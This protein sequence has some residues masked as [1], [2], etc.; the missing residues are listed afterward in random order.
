MYTPKSILKSVWGYDSFREPQEEIIESVLKNH[1]TIALLPTGGGKSICYQIPA[2]L[3]SGATL[4]ISPLISLMEDQVQQLQKRGVKA[5]YIKPGSSTEDIVTLFDAIKYGELKI[6]YLSP[7]RL[8]SNLIIEKLKEIEVSLLAIDEAHCISEWGHD[9]RPS[10]LKIKDIR[11]VLGNPKLIAVTASATNQVL[12]DIQIQLNCN[13][14]T[15]FKQ[16]FFR[17][18]LAYQVFEIESKNQRLFQI[19]SK[20]QTP[21]IVYV[22][23]RRR[24]KEIA[25]LLTEQGFL[26]T[27]YHGGMSRQEKEKAFLE[28]ISE[29][30][31]IIVAT[32]AFGMGIDKENVG[33]V[34]HIDLPYSLENYF[35]E[36]GRAG[37][38]GKK[39][40]SVLL[41]NQ[42][43]ID[44]FTKQFIKT[45]PN[46][47]FIKE[48]TQ[49]LYQHFHISNG[50]INSNS[51]DFN[52]LEFCKLYNF[53]YE[54]ARTS[55]QVLINQGIIELSQDFYSRSTLQ[56]IVSPKYLQQQ[57]EN[58][59]LDKKIVN[60]L[61]RSYSGLFSNQ[62]KIDEF[63]LS[64][65]IGITSI[66]LKKK[67]TSLDEK[68]LLTFQEKS[69]HQQ[70]FF[71][72]P[73][74]DQYQINR[75]SKQ[76]KN[77][78]NQ[79]TSKGKKLINF[80]LS[81][82][83]CRS[84]LLLSYFDQNQSL[85]CGICDIC[86]KRKNENSRELECEI[87][88]LLKNKNLSS[89]EIFITLNA[90]EDWVLKALKNLLKKEVISINIQNQYYLNE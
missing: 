44:V 60:V 39:A 16:S 18:N 74:E 30:K 41:Y 14:A 22:N 9:F 37:R 12:E 89:K 66:E 84:R 86:L 70:L 49:K 90:Q 4:I 25:N 64:K 59:H 19:F 54:T 36:A 57:I 85:K 35:Q 3:F 7:E 81:K 88:D 40:F 43:D 13:N 32:N 2:I 69:D 56:I 58:T 87:L 23:S 10:F 6:I 26:A 20:I 55:L 50:E 31:R 68:N 75:V 52:F 24:T 8:Q 29:K 1:E 53:P 15:V 11:E 76:I 38:N 33:I 62:I 47:S 72:N 27:Y 71:L 5:S 67:L 28:W 78:L 46:L 51:F 82:D 79:K 77:Y 61:L 48:F 42:N 63:T 80:V 34:V 73:R 45:I 65:K 83:S 21:G 17:K